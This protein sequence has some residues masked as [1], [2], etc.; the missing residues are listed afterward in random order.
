MVQVRIRPAA[1]QMLDQIAVDLGVTRSDVI[2]E[3]CFL[4]LADPTRLRDRIERKKAGP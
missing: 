2:R 3:A 4:A 1:V